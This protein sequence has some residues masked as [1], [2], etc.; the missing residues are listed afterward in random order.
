MLIALMPRNEGH[1]SESLISVM[2]TMNEG[3]GS[4][5]LISVMYTMKGT[6]LATCL[7]V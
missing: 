7:K 6:F 5:S 4:E 1:G 2:Y 3:H